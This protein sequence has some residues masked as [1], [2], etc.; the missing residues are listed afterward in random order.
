MT[1]V[2]Q[3]RQ[4]SARKQFERA[5]VEHLKVAAFTTEQ[6]ALR[7]P[8]RRE[9]SAQA[10]TEQRRLEDWT[11]LERHREELETLERRVQASVIEQAG[12]Q[13][14]IEET[15]AART[16]IAEHRAVLGALE[17]MVTRTREEAAYGR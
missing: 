9:L 12:L 10:A 13:A 3:E 5:I 6:D 4:Q 7:Q 11:S 2:S 1:R 16:R 15:E 8:V 14:L 17:D